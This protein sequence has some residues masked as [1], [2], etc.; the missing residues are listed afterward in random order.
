MCLEYLYLVISVILLAVNFSIA[1]VYQQDNG[2]SLLSGT[3]YNFLIAIASAVIFF[4]VNKFNFE[5]NGFSFCV[6]AGQAFCVNM[7]TLIGFKLIKESSLSTYTFFLMTGG[8][9]LPYIYGLAF[10]N[11]EP[12]VLRTVGLVVIIVSIILVNGCVKKINPKQLLMCVAVFALNGGTSIFSKLHQISPIAISSNGYV[13]WSSALKAVISGVML[14]ALLLVFGKGD[15]KSEEA[16]V[17]LNAKSVILILLSAAISGASY[18]LQLVGAIT[19]D[20]SVLYPMITGG[21]I[22]FTML[23]DIIVFK[24]KPTKSM[25]LGAV[26]V[27]AGTCMFL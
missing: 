11:E 14:I 8:M 19:I 25:I 6:A 12:S 16:Q 20:A 23:A 5:I 15:K 22:F 3:K 18:F 27:I 2:T 7:Y 9:V 13:A 21:A 17:K 1:K 24:E 10:L 26:L 4:G